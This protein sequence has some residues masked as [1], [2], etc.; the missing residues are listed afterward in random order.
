MVV[1]V[2]RKNHERVRV[3]TEMGGE[4]KTKQSFKDDCDINVIVGRFKGSGE[5]HHLNRA[6]PSY[7]DSTNSTD[8]LTAYDL[9]AEAEEGF[10]SLPAS[11]R[12]A[13]QN[14]PGILLGMMESPEGQDLLQEAGMMF[15]RG[16]E[17]PAPPVEPPVVP[18]VVPPAV[19]PVE[20]GE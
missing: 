17:P 3:Q 1:P 7:I 4:S 15:D 14:D 13:A 12:T 6:S 8:L 16:P 2:I 5:V 11:V 19:P 10:M 9:V 18:P 20:G